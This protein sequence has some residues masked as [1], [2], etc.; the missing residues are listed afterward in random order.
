MLTPCLGLSKTFVDRMSAAPTLSGRAEATHRFLRLVQPI[1]DSEL[2]SPRILEAGR[3]YTFPFTF[4]VPDRLLPRACPH[5]VRNEQVRDAHLHL[6]PSLG[7]AELAGFGGRLLDDL[8]PEMSKVT[9]SIRVML[10]RIKERDDDEYETVIAQKSRKVRVKPAFDEA[11]PLRVDEAEKEYTLREEKSIRRGMFKGRT[12]LGKL[13]IESAQPRAFVLPYQ[14]PEANVS[15][16]VRVNLRFDPAHGDT[17][18]VPPG[19]NNIQSKLKVAT[20]FASGPRANFPIRENT[21]IDYSQSYHSEA[22]SLSQRCL[23]SVNWIKHNSSGYT[24]PEPA[25]PGAERRDSE[26]SLSYN[27]QQTPSASSEYAGDG[28]YWTAHILVPVTLPRNKHFVPTFHTCIISRVYAISLHLAL[29]SPGKASP[30]Q[31]ITLRVPV[32][33]AQEGTPEL[34][35]ERR[36]SLRVEEAGWEVDEVF[37]PRR[38]TVVDGQILGNNASLSGAAGSDMPP[39]YEGFGGGSTVGHRTAGMSVSVH[40]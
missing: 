16:A 14:D 26:H 33:V 24:T 32:Q 15:T 35:Q 40:G 27:L 12:K 34:E 3:T 23:A 7:D 6:P 31:T 11:P 37:T 18:T 8:A 20:F 36:E 30:G 17:K 13:V 29:Q 25:S 2:P 28:V 1:T 9:Y 10:T 4:R 21:T 5:R 22:L 38:P 39:T 19:L